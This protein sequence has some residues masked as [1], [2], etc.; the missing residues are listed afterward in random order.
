MTGREATGGFLPGQACTAQRAVALAATRPR[1]AVLSGVSLDLGR[2]EILGL[3]GLVGQGQGHLLEALFGAHGSPAARSC[4]RRAARPAERRA[5]AIRAG[6]AYVPQERKTEGLL[7]S[8]SVGQQHDAGHPRPMRALFGVV[9]PRGEG[10][11]VR[12]AIARAKI[13]T[14]GG[15][16]D[17]SATSA[18]ATSRRC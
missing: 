8:K 12:T 11:L 9:E 7:L 5:R 6:L 1:S 13:R 14:R 3:G 4:R 17:R 2:G 15:A 16:R 10:E 18:A